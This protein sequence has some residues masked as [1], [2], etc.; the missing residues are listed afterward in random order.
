MKIF[1]IFTVLAGVV[2]TVNAVPKPNP[3]PDETTK[4]QQAAE[5]YI[6]TDSECIDVVGGIHINTGGCYVIAQ[7]SFAIIKVNEVVGDMAKNCAGDYIPLKSNG[8]EHMLTIC[9]EQ[10]YG[11]RLF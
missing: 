11:Q 6:F 4:A 3:A 9:S 8:G 1:T 7:P 2:V 5:I 10:S